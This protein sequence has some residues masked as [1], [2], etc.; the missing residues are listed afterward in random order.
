MTSRLKVTSFIY[1]AFMCLLAW[2]SLLTSM[3]QNRMH[4]SWFVDRMLI[5]HSWSLKTLASDHATSQEKE[6]QKHMCKKGTNHIFSLYLKS[7]SNIFNI[8]TQLGLYFEWDTIY[9]GVFGFG[10][11][12][13][14]K[15][16]AP[17]AKDCSLALVYDIA[18]AEQ[19]FLVDSQIRNISKVLHQ[20]HS[21]TQ[22]FNNPSK[23]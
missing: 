15:C 1:V 10:E 20:T 19:L 16:I 3:N 4:V 8:N 6:G 22:F 18:L 14:H 13:A 5:K 12:L 21:Q 23:I 9:P 17:Y 2:Q 7:F 11:T